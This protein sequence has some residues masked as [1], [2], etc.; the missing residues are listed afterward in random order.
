MLEYYT[1]V[2]YRNHGQFNVS[3]SY[4]KADETVIAPEYLE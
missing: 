2:K 4:R 3:Y 1:S